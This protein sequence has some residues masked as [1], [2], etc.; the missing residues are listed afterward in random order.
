MVAAGK[1]A[2]MLEQIMG[3]ILALPGVVLLALWNI[4]VMVLNGVVPII[5]AWVASALTTI[6]QIAGYAYGVL[7]GVIVLIVNYFIAFGQYLFS[8]RSAILWTIHDY[9]WSWAPPDWRGFVA[10]A[11]PGGIRPYFLR[12]LQELSRN[13]T[14]TWV[15][16]EI[17]WPFL[18][19]FRLIWLSFVKPIEKTNRAA[20]WVYKSAYTR[21][22]SIAP[23]RR[24]VHRF[25]STPPVRFNAESVNRVTPQGVVDLDVDDPRR[26]ETALLTP[27]VVVN[28]EGG[29]KVTVDHTD[30]GCIK[31]GEYISPN[32]SL[33]VGWRE[34]KYFVRN[35]RGARVEEAEYLKMS[36]RNMA[37]NPQTVESPL[38]HPQ[39]EQLVR[40][41]TEL[42]A[43]LRQQAM[44]RKRTDQLLL[45][46]K[47]KALKWLADNKV[48]EEFKLRQAAF[49]VALAWVPCDEELMALAHID[50]PGA[51]V[52]IALRN[53]MFA[54]GRGVFDGG[55]DQ[56]PSNVLALFPWYKRPLLWSWKFANWLLPA[57]TMR[58]VPVP[59]E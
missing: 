49:C 8:N 20:N 43:Y 45:V 54:G 55:I 47:Q 31:N 50:S 18:L 7:L 58:L 39:G 6:S 10:H 4:T 11:S 59:L 56:I 48:S 44:F 2:F 38:D 17:L 35:A 9:A 12:R 3:N 40:V 32:V 52:R 28:P 34:T 25:T 51:A 27:T 19:P 16:A 36:M 46:L 23:Y 30:G 53:N 57:M 41:S 26:V 29:R 37:L 21:V 22:S 24:R 13:E 15:L 14:F 33:D 42:V 1:T 5:G